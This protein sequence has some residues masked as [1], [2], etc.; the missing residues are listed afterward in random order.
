MTLKLIPSFL[1][2]QFLVVPLY[3]PAEIKETHQIIEEWIDTESLISEESSKW[4][5][6]KLRSWI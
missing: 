3:L 5:S 2:S 1:I 6:E 4:K